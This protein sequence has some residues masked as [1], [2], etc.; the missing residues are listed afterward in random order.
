[1]AAAEPQIDQVM[2]FDSPH[3]VFQRNPF[4]AAT[5][6]LS[7]FSEAA[8][9]LGESEYN[10]QRIAHFGP[11]DDT[12]AQ[13]PIISSSILR[14]GIGVLR[15]FYRRLLAEY[16]GRAELLTVEK[17]IQGAINRV[18]HSG[19][20]DFPLTIHPNGAEVLFEIWPSTLPVTAEH[21]VRCGD[22][23]P[24]AIYS[25][26]AA[27]KARQALLRLLRIGT[28]RHDSVLLA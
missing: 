16:V 3:A 7:V 20:L 22:A 12:L 6:G 26:Q 19:R 5:V 8:A 9:R 18:C 25:P 14:G 28:P 13:R 21:A 1:M 27:T 4:A 10:M 15:M 2:L 17:G 23:V 11:F 24:A